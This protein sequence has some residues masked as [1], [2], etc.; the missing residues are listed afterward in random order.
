MRQRVIPRV[1]PRWSTLVGIFAVGLVSAGCA[2]QLP[3]LSAVS[4]ARAPGILRECQAIFPPGPW[5]ATH[6]VEASMPMGNDTSLIGVVAADSKPEGFRSLLM[7]A[8]GIVLFNAVYRQGVIEVRRAL[9]PLDPTGFGRAMIG[10]VHLLLF[11]PS[12]RLT[13]VGELPNGD[14]VCRWQ[15]GEEA[16]DAIV[17]RGRVVRLL[18]FESG[19]LVR[20]VKFGEPNASGLPVEAWLETQGMIGY[21]LHLRLLEFTPGPVTRSES[22]Q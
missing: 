5:Q 1:D 12:G 18:R 9:P 11:A 7:T 10:D 20:E 6:V 14:G 21:R 22:G 3:A 17:A 2:R 19:S 8:E 4:P 15:R 13:E 16:V